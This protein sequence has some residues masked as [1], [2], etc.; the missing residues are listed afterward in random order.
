MRRCDE[1]EVLLAHPVS[2]NPI[3]PSVLTTLSSPKAVWIDV[4]LLSKPRAAGRLA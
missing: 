1:S 3:N 4:A 2:F